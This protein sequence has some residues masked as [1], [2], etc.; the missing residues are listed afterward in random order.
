MSFDQFREYWRSK[1]FEKVIELLL[2]A[3]MA[4]GRA[5]ADFAL[6]SANTPHL[7]YDEVEKRS[8]IPLLNIIDCLAEV[9]KMDGISKIGL[10]GTKYTLTLGFYSERLRKHGLEALVPEKEDID[11]VNDIIFNELTWGI[12]REGSRRKVMKIMEKLKEKGSEAVALACTELPLLFEGTREIYGMKL[13]DTA[14][15][16]AVKALDYALGKN[17]CFKT[18]EI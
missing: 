12:I 13:Y 9:A 6:I 7:F 14:K 4:L 2:K 1:K 16:D 11:I 8:P 3:V 18:A 15:I 17:A 5:G 10:L